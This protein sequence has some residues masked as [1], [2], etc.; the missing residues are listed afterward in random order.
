MYARLTNRL[1]PLTMCE[2]EVD[3]EAVADLRDGRARGNHGVDLADL[4]RGWLSFQIAGRQASS[5]RVADRLKAEGLSG[6]L[7][8]EAKD[9]HVNLVLWCWGPNLP[10]KVDVY[11]LSGCLPRNQL[12]WQGVA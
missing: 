1:Q 7:V 12:S 10:H 8:P 9:A 4:A 3:C 6:M 11:Y 5:W 2:Y